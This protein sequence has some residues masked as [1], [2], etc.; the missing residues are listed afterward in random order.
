MRTHNYVPPRLPGF[1]CGVCGVTA[2]E[3]ATCDL[4]KIQTVPMSEIRERYNPGEGRHFFDRS[5][6]RFFRSKLP[7]Y[8]YE[9]PGGVY[10][11]T[12]EQFIGISGV[13]SSR[14]YTVRQLL[15][16]DGEPCVNTVGEF[17]VMDA[18]T[19]RYMAKGYAKAGHK[20]HESSVA[21]FNS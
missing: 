13:P 17:N 8:G 16:R 2:A 10:F 5:S 15:E 20:K 7:A 11:V 14:K 6:M 9:G 4:M 18:R 1:R 12:S 3:H 21:A 19:A